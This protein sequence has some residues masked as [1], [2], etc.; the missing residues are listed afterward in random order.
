MINEAARR[1][2]KEIDKQQAIEREMVTKLQKD[3]ENEKSAKTQKRIDEREYALK[4]IREN[5]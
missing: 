4:V 1:K 3:I 2:Q 5:E